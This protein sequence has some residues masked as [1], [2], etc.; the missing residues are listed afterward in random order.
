MS[1]TTW[2]MGLNLTSEMDKSKRML[3]YVQTWSDLGLI[4]EKNIVIPVSKE[5]GGLGL[6]TFKPV[7][8][9]NYQFIMKIKE[10]LK[11]RLKTETWKGSLG[12]GLEKNSGLS[13]LH[14]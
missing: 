1:S 7:R 12:L 6:E 11:A 14:H 10:I 2:A 5:R 8:S 13:L 4:L 3:K 9:K